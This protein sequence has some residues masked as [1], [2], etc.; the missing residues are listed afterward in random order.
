LVKTIP[1][2]DI[3]DLALAEDVGTGDVTTDALIPPAWKGRGV[4]F[5]KSPGVLA[6]T[7]AIREVFRRVDPAV[8]VVFRFRD[9]TRLEAGD[10]AGTVTG[11]Y[12]SL[13]K[14][15]RTALNFLQRL[16]G[17]A[18]L[19]ACYVEAL[20]GTKT[21]ILDTRKTTPGLRTLEKAAVKAGGG[22]NHR[23]GLF[24]A[25]LIKDNHLA[26]LRSEDFSIDETIRRARKGAPGRKL[27][28][29]VCSTKDAR[30]SA[31]AGADIIMLDNMSLNDMRRA[32]KAVAGRALV[33]ASGGV[34]L[35]RVRAIAETGV[36]FISVGALTHSAP[37]LDISL[38]IKLLEGGS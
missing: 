38:E 7:Q 24:D 26:A 18:T 20:K 30:V 28:I 11:P 5:F 35:E 3:F 9:G 12:A 15:E 34:T 25:V 2:A 37:S 31:E 17:I 13:L 4:F 6:G 21:I 16:S 14:G 8:K 19:T 23:F 33:E 32:V 29:E 22:T 36:D 27:E 10:N 1:L